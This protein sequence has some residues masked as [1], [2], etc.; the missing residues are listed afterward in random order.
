MVADHVGTRHERFEVQPDALEIVDRLVESYDEP[1]SDSSAVPTWYL[2]EM[3]RKHVTVALSGDGGDELFGG[4]ERYRAL[5]LS[6]Q[7]QRWLPVR[8][9]SQAWWLKR[10]P[11]STARRSLLRRVRR[12]C[13]AL[14]Q[15]APNRYMNW[16]QIF[17]EAQ[18]LDLY[19]ESWIS[20]LPNRD[21][22]DF[23]RNAWNRAL[24]D[25]DGQPKKPPRDPM[26][27]AMAADLQTYLPCD[28]MT[29]V[30]IASMAH[31]LEAR[32]PFLDYRLVEW[33][34]SL[35]VGLKM[36]SGRGKWLLYQTYRDLLPAA[37]WNR[38][39]MGFGVPIAK[40]FRTSLRDRTYDALLSPDSR[41]H[42][43]LRPEAIRAMVDEH[44]QGRGNQAY[45]L[46]NLLILELWLRR[47]Q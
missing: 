27:C 17:G 44:M 34:S 47:W 21:P 10:L 35:P 25:P 43:F 9:L 32:Q 19:E 12:F 24:H 4:Y 8:S 7:M 13:E 23:L 45:R 22:V 31:S 20:Q 36:R 26:S 46:W 1:F 3:T 14:G 42:A 29:K 41:C 2:C 6:E 30:D 40:W 28:L 38:P 16:I 37:I 15:S 33:A 5:Q 39:K 18:R 11:D